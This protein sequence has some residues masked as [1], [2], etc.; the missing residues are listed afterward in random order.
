M[1]LTPQDLG[2]ERYISILRER[3]IP[4]SMYSNPAMQGGTALRKRRTPKALRKHWV[5]DLN[6][7]EKTADDAADLVLQGTPGTGMKV[8]VILA[9]A[10]MWM[11]AFIALGAGA[12]PVFPL[13]FV[14]LWFAVMS[15]SLSSPR[16]AL[17]K[18]HERTLTVSEVESLLPTAR[19]RLERMYLHLTL[20]VMRQE[21]PSESA[22]NDIRAALRHLGD[23]IS[24]LPAEPVSTLDAAALRREALALRQQAAT[25]HDSFVQSSLNRQ[26]ETLERR[27]SLAAQ[28]SR[29]ARRTAALRREAR[30]Q[31]DALRSVLLAHAQVDNQSVSE[32]GRLSE[33]VHRISSEAQALSLAQRE[34]EDEEIERLFGASV[35][36]TEIQPTST[37]A[38]T[39]PPATTQTAQTDPAAQQQQVVQNGLSGSPGTPSGETPAQPQTP[40]T[41]QWWRSGN[42]G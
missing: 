31:M 4:I 3:L 41:K 26:A 19:G 33:V 40:P 32:V 28:N 35:P 12:P 24:K 11:A 20:D 34:L 29:S 16:R 13:L 15:V 30:L 37:A 1:D 14:F 22:R 2:T 6:L 8:G 38:P 5:R 42:V 36:S 10:Y 27:A 21:I 9:T 23:A 18:A 25:E 39:A 17:K 7:D